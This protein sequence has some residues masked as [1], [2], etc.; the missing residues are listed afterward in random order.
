MSKQSQN[1]T[2]ELVEQI[3]IISYEQIRLKN[4]EVPMPSWT[5]A[6]A[7]TRY[8]AKQ[9]VIGV[10]AMVVPVL[11]E[12]GW[13]PPAEPEQFTETTWDGRESRVSGRL[14]SITETRAGEDQ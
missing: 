13:T 8:Q 7:M 11:L 5:G 1:I 4:C 2:E 9:D 10:L 12:Q 3:A 6:G 14:P